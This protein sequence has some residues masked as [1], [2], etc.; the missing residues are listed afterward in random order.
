MSSEDIIDEEKL[1]D[2]LDESQVDNDTQYTFCWSVTRQFEHK[3]AGNKKSYW[4]NVAKSSDTP[5]AKC[6]CVQKKNGKAM[7]VQYNRV[8]KMKNT[9][10]SGQST[11]DNVKV[12]WRYFE[13]MNFLQASTIAT[14]VESESNMV[15]IQEVFQFEFSVRFT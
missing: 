12:T 3:S 8:L 1:D 10:K 15:N 11:D 2:E 13:A 7:R 6:E 9:K 5:I 4:E 14:T